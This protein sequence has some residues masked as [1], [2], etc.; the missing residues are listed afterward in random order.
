MTDESYVPYNEF[1]TPLLT[2][3]YQISM[4]YAY[5]CNDSH[6]RHSVFD[7]FFRKN[8]FKGE[9]TVFAGLDDCLRFVNAFRFTEKS[10]NLLKKEFSEW[11]PAFFDWLAQ[12]DASQVRIFAVREGSVVF[13]RTPLLRVEGPLAVCQL[14]ETTLLNLVNFASLIATNAAR[15]RQAAP[16]KTLIEFGLRR[17]QGPDG[18]MSASRY[19]YLGGFD[20]TSNVAAG[21]LF[22][23]KLSGTHAHSFVS[24]FTSFDELKKTTLMDI[25]GEEREFLQVCLQKRKEL[26]AANAND[27]ELAAF[28]AYAQARPRGFLALVD[29]YDTLSSGVPNFLAVTLALHEFGYRA[30]G[31]RLDS[32]DLAYLSRMCREQFTRCGRQFNLPWVHALN[33]VAS[34]D[35]SE[36]VI[37][38]LNEQGHSI[39]VF[40]IGTHLVTCK[41]QPALGCVYK[42]VQIEGRPRIK[43]SQDVVKVTIPSRKCAYR[44]FGQDD[45]PLLDLLVP[46]DSLE[47]DA[48][49]HESSDWPANPPTAGQ[50]ILCRSPFYARKR[51]FVTPSRVERLHVLA[52]DRGVLQQDAVSTLDEARQR[53]QSQVKALRRDHVRFL[54]PTPYKVSVTEPLFEFL[55]SLWLAEAP[56]SELS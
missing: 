9:Y 49:H 22:N 6:D 41:K 7:L 23:V 34:N 28:V 2:D 3:M 21:L 56:I 15:H 8:P 42:L 20:G 10:I 16:D 39:D 27:S 44:L 40:G 11:E 1:V 48:L 43:L 37:V 52:W 31:I 12:V 36:D 51:A 46:V 38:S 5:W 50:R 26:E 45:T 19:A 13:P 30:I 25:K 55:H 33:I 4:A 53:C 54:N 32:G 47:G 14:L 18:A 17:A 35:L 24:S 29:T